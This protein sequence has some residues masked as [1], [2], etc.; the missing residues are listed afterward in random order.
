MYAYAWTQPFS[1]YIYGA[2]Y[3]SISIAGGGYP[4]SRLVLDDRV[5]IDGYH[6]HIPVVIGNHSSIPI[7]SRHKSCLQD[8]MSFARNL[9][10]SQLFIRDFGQ[11][12]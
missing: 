1:T 6:S 4:V 12:H 3:L 8:I 9:R 7:K 5:R 2:V 11:D 10:F